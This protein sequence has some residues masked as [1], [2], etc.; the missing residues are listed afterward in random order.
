M[1]DLEGELKISG[2]ICRTRRRGVTLARARKSVTTKLISADRLKRGQGVG[3][4]RGRGW[5]AKLLVKHRQAG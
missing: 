3:K 2:G 4:G 1:V 5:L